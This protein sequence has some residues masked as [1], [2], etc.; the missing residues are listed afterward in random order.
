V[1]LEA[2]IGGD[3]ALFVGEDKIFRLEVLDVSQIPVNITGWA[4]KLVVRKKDNT[5]DPAIF[6]R[7]ALVVGVYNAVRT[8]NTQ[9]A[10]VQLTDTELNTV[11]KKTYRHSWKR[12][13]DGSE[14]VLAY[15]DFVVQLATAR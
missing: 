7:D 8:T 2:T 6:S 12:M 14:T 9:R 15:G 13:D 5:A 10:E 3:G 11:S 1:A 4:I